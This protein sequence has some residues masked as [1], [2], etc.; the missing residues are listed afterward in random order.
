MITASAAIRK[1]YQDKIEKARMAELRQLTPESALDLYEDIYR[2]GLE[3]QAGDPAGFKRIMK[4][5]RGEK[6]A[7]RKKMLVVFH[8]LDRI[9][10]D[11]AT[12]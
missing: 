7:L 5:R 1:K 10:H 12:T 11:R 9:R 6:Y 2:L 4:I 3:A 8:R